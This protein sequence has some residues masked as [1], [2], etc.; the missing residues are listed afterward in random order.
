MTPPDQ[1]RDRIVLHADGASMF[2]FVPTGSELALVRRDERAVTVGDV[3]CFPNAEGAI[4][5]HRVVAC[6]ASHADQTCGPSWIVR[7]DAIGA[8][9]LVPDAA[10]AWIVT[11]V[12]RGRVR[13]RT[14]GALG[15]WLA[16][17][18]VRRG[19]TYRACH[20]LARVA[21]WLRRLARGPAGRRVT[22][23]CATRR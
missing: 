20:R 10:I 9:E 4:V 17:V 18:A 6:A 13:Y 7:G 8:A 14:D 23:S 3:V 19:A 21:V 11:H 15:V 12:R 1:D 16:R 5:A 22:S 2:P